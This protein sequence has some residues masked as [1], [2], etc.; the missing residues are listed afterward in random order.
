MIV[1]PPDLIEQLKM[2]QNMQEY[3]VDVTY[4]GS[5]AF[6]CLQQYENIIKV[7]WAVC[8]LI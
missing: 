1:F 8:Y 4:T 3:S 7:Y 6:I 2:N 5:R